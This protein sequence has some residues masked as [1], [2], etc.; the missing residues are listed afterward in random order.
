MNYFCF[1][2][3]YNIP[4]DIKQW[5]AVSYVKSWLE[6]GHSRVDDE[7]RQPHNIETDD[8]DVP[9]AEFTQESSIANV[10]NDEL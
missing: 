2:C 7:T 8:D 6:H 10:K 1:I 4:S 3:R 5:N 9:D